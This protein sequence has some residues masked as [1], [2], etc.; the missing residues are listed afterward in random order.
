MA[1]ILITVLNGAASASQPPTA[2]PDPAAP[3]G[4]APRIANGALH[5]GARNIDLTARAVTM[6][7]R[8]RAA[9]RA[10]LAKHQELV[11]EIY[12]GVAND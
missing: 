4:P 7:N 8:D 5:G 10:Y 3:Y 1:V 9:A 6:A 11:S 2:S 12:S